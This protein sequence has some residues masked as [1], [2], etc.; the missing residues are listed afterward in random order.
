[1]NDNFE[2][3]T[4]RSKQSALSNPDPV[5]GGS[6]LGTATPGDASD[7]SNMEYLG[8]QYY[9]DSNSSNGMIRLISLYIAEGNTT[10]DK[11]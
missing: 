5:N 1:M 10:I 11:L 8:V 4:D 6:R 9:S 7:G 2:D 3:V